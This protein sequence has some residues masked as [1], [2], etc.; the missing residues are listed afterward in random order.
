MAAL[1]PDGADQSINQKINQPT[2]HKLNYRQAI[3]AGAIGN[4]VEWYDWTIYGLLAA[5]FSQEI[6]PTKSATASLLATFATFAVGFLFRPLGAAVLSP[7]GDRHGRRAL[8]AVTVGLM[9][10]GSLAIAVVPSYHTSGVIA[11]VIFVLARLLQGF[12]A[13][14]EF[15][16]SSA[17]IVEHAP[18]KHRALFGSI[19]LVTIGM[20]VLAA[21]G[22]AAG[23]TGLIPE[24]AL[25]I[26]GWRIGFGIGA[27][28]SL[29]ALYIRLRAPETPAFED[30]KVKREIAEHPILEV[31]QHH[32]PAFWRVFAVEMG[33]VMF[34][35]WTV[36]LPTYA[37]LV[38]GLP[39]SQGLYGS[40]IALAVFV[41]ALPVVG[42]ASDAGV[43]RKPFLMAEAIGFLVLAYPMFEFISRGT[44]ASYLI[45][46]I[47]G[48]LLLA[49]VDGVMATFF[50]ELLPTRARATG[51][52]LPYALCAA[53]LGGTA[54]LLATFLISENHSLLIAPYVMIICVIQLS[55]FWF[56]PETRGRALFDH[57]EGTTAGELDDAH[58]KLPRPAR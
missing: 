10:A 47:V 5:T 3:T 56:T 16:G 54:P 48:V 45:V 50:C 58:L 57:E 27:V 18:L 52:G 31:F 7:F 29:Y 33:T 39:L 23:I 28:I 44:F 24:P 21:T 11:P 14:G 8:M 1:T 32:M 38:G 20:A 43:G 34:Y 26:W 55:I 35:I 49:C 15:Q 22:V 40:M 30:I 41:V 46:D 2:V 12:S 6:F 9:G 36:F 42:W 25:K 4:L 17:F 51:I 13:G 37:H 53:A 19:Q